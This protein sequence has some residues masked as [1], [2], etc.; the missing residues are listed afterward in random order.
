MAGKRSFMVN[1]G[2]DILSFISGSSHVWIHLF[3]PMRTM[4]AKLYIIA[5]WLLFC[6]FA[7]FCHWCLFSPFPTLVIERHAMSDRTFS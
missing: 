4:G 7:C 3:A 5:S 6:T 2:D 1:A